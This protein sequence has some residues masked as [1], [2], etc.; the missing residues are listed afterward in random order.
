MTFVSHAQN[1]EDVMLWRC[2]GQLKTGFYIDIGAGDPVI[3]SVTKSFYENGWS[4]IN[5]DPTKSAFTK[6]EFDR[7]RDI[8]LQVAV[9]EREGDIEFW[10]IP[11]TGLSTAVKN[12]AD[13]HESAGFDVNR[14]SVKTRTLKS[15]C[16][17][18]VRSPINFLKIDVEGF[19]KKVLLGADFEKFRP[20]VIIIES[21]EPNSQV[22]NHLE[23]E[24]LLTE[25][26]YYYCY[27]DGLNR[28]YLAK[29]S[30]ILEVHFKYP[31]NV[32]DQFIISRSS[33]FFDA[34]TVLEFENRLQ[35]SLEERIRFLEQSIKDF[36]YA[37]N[38]L[39]QQRDELTQQRD[40]LLN[41]TIWKLTK[42]IR[43]II[44]LFKG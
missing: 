34:N 39:T 16:T 36:E 40:S 18:L 32:F 13:Q 20:M 22:E 15:I 26:N 25:S 7:P 30:E 5:I 41:S 8:N 44:E 12:F 4:G 3:D 43:V 10:S 38:E 2:F 24:Y 11:S 29:E 33:L 1:F 27:G 17:E 19:E 42:P 23:W 35:L 9:A 31:P 21:T 6:L 37:K 28:Y 14:I